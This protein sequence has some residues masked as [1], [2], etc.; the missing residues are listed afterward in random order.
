MTWHPWCDC[1]LFL[2]YVVAR[3]TH[4][5]NEQNNQD[6]P[7]YSTS[8]L[9]GTPVKELPKVFTT[10]LWGSLIY[11]R[12]WF[13]NPRLVLNKASVPAVTFLLGFNEKKN[14]LFLIHL[15]ELVTVISI[16]W[17]EGLTRTMK[18]CCN[19]C[20]FLETFTC[21]VLY[22]ESEL[23]GRDGFLRKPTNP[24]SQRKH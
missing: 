6:R 21:H 9:Q 17:Q 10:H 24:A 12:P 5:I 1:S 15:L 16:Q 2:Q 23:M 20:K 14:L 13:T 3:E 19:T 11:R 4:F 8:H 22:L 18:R 7:F